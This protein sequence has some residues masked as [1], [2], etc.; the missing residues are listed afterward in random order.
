MLVNSR[1]H[2]VFISSRKICPANIR[3]QLLKM[4]DVA[5]EAP[6]AKATGAVNSSTPSRTYRSAASKL[7]IV[8]SH[9][10]HQDEDDQGHRPVGAHPDDGE[11]HRA[12]IREAQAGQSGG[13]YPAVRCTADIQRHV[14]DVVG[15]PRQDGEQ[16][17]SDGQ[18][19][20]VFRSVPMPRPK[21]LNRFHTKINRIRPM[22]RATKT[23]YMV[24]AAG[25]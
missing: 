14:H 11:K 8:P 3:H 2:Q 20:G 12:E 25:K 24:S 10:Q 23:S 21:F 6:I 19:H 7:D 22:A 1:R 16:D 9:D 18:L 5:W 13:E 4:L 15:V 17:A